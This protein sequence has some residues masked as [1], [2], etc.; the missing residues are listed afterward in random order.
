MRETRDWTTIRDQAAAVSEPLLRSLVG[1]LPTEIRHACGVHFGWWTEQGAASAGQP[2]GKAVRPALALLACRAAGGAAQAAHPAA[3]AVELV[4]NAGLLHDDI[5]DR[6][7]VRRGRPALWKAMGVP[8]AI[9]AGDALFFAAVQALTE[10]P[11][12]DRTVPVLLATVR[13]LV[14]GEYLDTLLES[15]AAA[16]EEQVLAV[17]AGKTGALLACACELGAIA[18]DAT[19]ERAAH[20]R[21]FGHHLGIAFQCADDLLGIWGDPAVTGKP[22]LSDL[23]RRKISL[24]VAVALADRTPHTARLRALYR[25]DAPLSDEDCRSAAEVI[26]RTGAR[27]VTERWGDRHSAEALRHLR[28]AG[29]EPGPRAE[30]EALVHLATH[31]DH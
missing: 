16:D 14:E 25:R 17:A 6:D 26:T 20:L 18:A 4:H 12:P 23:R 30:L 27:R 7:P 31:R 15:E 1:S 2:S 22:A 19:D 8:A 21:A 5:I 13:E 28:L 24:P 9:L 3:V 11:R 29:P 10:A